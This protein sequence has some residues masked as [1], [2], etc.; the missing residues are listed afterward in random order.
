MTHRRSRLLTSVGTAGI[1]CAALVPLVSSATAAPG[2][3][4]Q[5]PTAFDATALTPGLEAT[6]LTTAGYYRG[7]PTP[8]SNTAPEE[9]QGTYVGTLEDAA[10]DLFLFDLSGSRI[11]KADGT[12]DAGIWAGISGSPLHAA[13]GSLIGS[14][15]YAFTQIAGST[16]AGVTPAADLY[17]LLDETGSAPAARVQLDKADRTMLRRAG[18]VDEAGSRGLN[19][20]TAPT[21]VSGVNGV[22]AKVVKAIAKKS[23]VTAPQITSGAGTQDQEIPVV[24]GGN[25]AVANAYGSLALYSVGTAAA[26][27]DD[28][29][30]GYGHANNW[31]P[32]GATI[33]GASTATIIA[34]GAYSYKMANLGA[35]VGTLLHDRLNGITGRLGASLPHSTTV[36]VTTTGPKGRAT[37]TVVAEPSMLPFVIGNQVYRD[38]ALT[39]DED[40]HG[41]GTITWDITYERANGSTKTFT[42]SD[43]YASD[44]SIANEMP[45]GVAGDVASILDNGFEDV[46]ITG[47]SVRQDVGRTY[48]AY[49]LGKTEL[50]VGGTW[51]TMRDY[52]RITVK[53]GKKVKVRMQLKRDGRL[54]DVAPKTRTFTFKVPK[55]AIGGGMLSVSGNGTS[56]WDDEFFFYD[57]DELF[58]DE[59]GS[60]Q[61][62]SFDGLLKSLSAA[63]RQ[64][65][66]T[67]SLTLVNAKGKQVTSTQT[68]RTGAVTFGDKAA[69]VKIQQVKKKNKKKK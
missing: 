61:P 2:D 20:L 52:G 32:T 13:D 56:F 66:L 8:A 60:G 54:A 12:I 14:V 59:G 62:T 18:A 53:P 47:V 22:P 34:D 28:V 3:S 69:L 15:S 16:I 19:R 23:G 37:E 68:W 33:H 64:D 50:K 57:E 35:P 31:Y 39:L 63:P 27:C 65:T 38:A 45:S 6:G 58:M 11:T 4:P 24:A 29:V 49:R 42:R 36:N 43:A 7:G 17:D 5:C 10:G 21:V 67:A 44:Y 46:T 41:S 40:A 48:R 51:K 30:I 1:L 26:V 25:V 55:R 9:F